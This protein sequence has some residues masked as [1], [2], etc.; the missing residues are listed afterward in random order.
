MQRFK[1]N[2]REYIMIITGIVLMA[3][4]MDLFLIPNKIAPGGFSGLATIIHYLIPIKVG[5]IIAVLNVPLFLVAF[6]KLG[7]LF[8]IKS[9]FAMIAYSFAIDALPIPCLTYDTLLAAIFGG[10]F[11]GLGIGSVLKAGATTGGTDTAAMLFL[12]VF[13]GM[14]VNWLIFMMDFLVIFLAA[15]VF[16]PELS[17]YGLATIF[18]SSKATELVLEGP[19]SSKVVIIM[20]RKSKLI[21]DRIINELKRGVTLLN[22]TGLYTNEAIDVLLCVVHREPEVQS[23]KDIVSAAD[24]GA[25]VIIGNVKEVLGKGFK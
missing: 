20:S 24:D 12:R 3:L 4:A 15:F 7:F 18:I 2:S 19:S 25:F 22:G 17:L 16:S 1:I 5:F 14:K 13:K 6:K 8:C 9:L 21:S 23:I 10:I 11:M